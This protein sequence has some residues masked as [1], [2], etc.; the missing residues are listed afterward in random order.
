MNHFRL[1]SL[2]VILI[3]LI[4]VFSNAS[5]QSFRDDNSDLSSLSRSYSNGEFVIELKSKSHKEILRSK[6]IKKFNKNESDSHDIKI[7]REDFN[8]LAY[9]VEQEAHDLSYEHKELV[10]QVILNRVYHEKFPN[11][12]S[13]V[14]TQKNQFQGYI[15]Y[16]TK[17]FKPTYETILACKKVLKNNYYNNILFFYN[18]DIAHPKHRQF[19]EH[20]KKLTH[21]RTIDGHSFFAMR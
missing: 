21:V 14:L 1:P 18:R 15:N 6:K 7:S 20:N 11:S 13:G 3:S 16:K 5:S 8:K 2:T 17:K 12:I 4:L 10:A 19:F 9:T